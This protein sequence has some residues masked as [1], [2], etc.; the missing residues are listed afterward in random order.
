LRTPGIS[1]ASIGLV[2]VSVVIGLGFVGTAAA[3]TCITGAGGF[4]G[5][6][7]ITISY[8]DAPTTTDAQ[9][10]HD[11][12]AYIQAYKDASWG[13]TTTIW[14]DINGNKLETSWSYSHTFSLSYGAKGQTTFFQLW[15]RYQRWQDY[16]SG[17]YKI[18]PYADLGRIEVTNKG[19]WDWKSIP[20]PGSSNTVVVSM[21]PGLPPVTVGFIAKSDVTNMLQLSV[22]V[23]VFGVDLNVGMSWSTTSSTSN[24]VEI[25][26]TN[27]GTT[28]A[29]WIVYYEYFR[30]SSGVI[31][32]FSAH[33]WRCS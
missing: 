5:A 28:R 11:A 6:K 32:A 23:H 18:T 19:N 33:V 17:Y 1:A 13:M 31:Y 10:S 25:T 21:D 27:P 9:Y 14:G 8:Q 24:R 20:Q 3:V 7:C 30:E 16:Y 12:N 4:A 15:F 22:G 29:A 26:F 2:L